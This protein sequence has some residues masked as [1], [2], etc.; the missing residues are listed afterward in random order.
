MEDTMTISSKEQERAET[1]SLVREGVLLKKEAAERLNLSTR[2]LR[3]IYKDFCKYGIKGLISKNRGKASNRKI[4]ETTVARIVERIKERYPD[5]K[6]T[7]AHEK[8]IEEDG[9]NLSL[10]SVRRIMI[11]SGI[12]APKA[13]KQKRVHTRR[14]RR[15]CFGELVQIDGSFHDWFEGRAPKC[16]LIVFVD[17]A[18]S[19]LLGLRF[20]ESESLIAYFQVAK[21]YF[22]EYGRPQ[23]F[24]ADKHGVFRVNHGSCMESK[25]TQFGR[26]MKELD[27][28]MISAHSP[29]AKGRVERANST[30]QDRLVKE[31][32][33]RN[34]SCMKDANTYLSEFCENYNNRFAVAPMNSVNAHR[35]LDHSHDLERILSIQETR[36]VSKTL[37]FQYENVHYQILEDGYKARSLI[38]RKVLVCKSLSGSV[39]VFNKDEKLSFT[40][41][42]QVRN[43]PVSLDSKN[44][45]S[46]LNKWLNKQPRYR[47]SKD[48]PWKR[49]II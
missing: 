20:V 18:T 38:K 31:L 49:R 35:D 3:R 10:S 42:N 39:T 26:A 8:L 28:R 37:S 45:N 5:F 21:K 9:F 17:D 29:Q 19:A 34:I 48:H 11:N 13:R 25:L 7:L 32:R 47:P 27:I 36:Q 2:Q 24:Y 44:L 12:L 33:L 22:T 6:P 16:C 40:T 30:L 46:E 15:S 23:A 14:E 1:L 43:Q 41:T 4:P